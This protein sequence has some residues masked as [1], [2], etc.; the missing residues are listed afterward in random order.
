MLRA[1]PPMAAKSS[2]NLADQA[3]DSERAINAPKQGGHA[4]AP[5]PVRNATYETYRARMSGETM[6]TIVLQ[7]R[8]VQ[9]QPL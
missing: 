5:S 1:A 4:M 8:N 6:V 2:F 9:G 7:T 3:E